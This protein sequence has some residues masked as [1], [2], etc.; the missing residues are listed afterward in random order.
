M[1]GANVER[2]KDNFQEASK[3]IFG[4]NFGRPYVLPN[5]VFAMSIYFDSEKLSKKGR[6]PKE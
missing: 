5:A 3:D 1:K 6:F 4:G 2:N